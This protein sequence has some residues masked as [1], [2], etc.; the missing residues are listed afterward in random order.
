MEITAETYTPKLGLSEATE[1]YKQL[2]ARICAARLF[3][4]SYLFYG[5]HAL[6]V[7]TTLG[8]VYYLMLISQSALAFTALAILLALCLTQLGGYMHDAAHMMIFKTRFM[9]NLFGGFCASL[10]F[11]NYNSWKLKH[12]AHHAHPNQEG[13]DPDLEIPI[14]SFTETRYRSKTG[15]ERWLR[16]Y[17]TYLYFPVSFLL[18]YS[19]QFKN[20]IEY[21][22]AKVKRRG[23]DL[24]S[25]SELIVYL[26]GFFLWYVLPFLVFDHAKAILFITIVPAT[27]GFYIA[28][29]FAPNHKGMPVIDRKTKLS[30]L[31][32]QIITSRNIAD[33]WFTDFIYL[34]LNYQIE[35]HLFVDC[36]RNKLKRVTPY[37]EELC[38]TRGLPFTVVGLRESF[39]V[40]LEGLQSV[41]RQAEHPNK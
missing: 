32:Q 30:F 35:H 25:A 19:L 26:G 29:V 21:L 40:I 41:V 23:F 20:S 24:A 12:A 33:N 7:F 10:I 11:M 4:R 5:L 18:A 2:H 13:G 31:E 3:E 8:A 28:S 6:C 34:S 27:S 16:R 14:F 38:R 39:G 15:L 36:P 9:N 22:V 1:L 37:V 17:Q